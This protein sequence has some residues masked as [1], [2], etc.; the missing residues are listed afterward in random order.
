[1]SMKNGQLHS[2]EDDT[3]IVRFSSAFHRDKASSHEGIANL[4]QQLRA[5]GT[6]LKVRCV[7]DT[8]VSAPPPMAREDSIDLAAAAMD[9]F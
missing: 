1:M 3:L 8:E 9:V 2:I 5:A 7:L 4:E 6:P